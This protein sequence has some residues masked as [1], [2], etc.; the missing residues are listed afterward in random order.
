MLQMGRKEMTLKRLQNRG[1]KYR[2]LKENRENS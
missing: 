2:G 1:G